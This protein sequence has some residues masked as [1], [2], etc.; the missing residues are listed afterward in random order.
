MPRDRRHPQLPGPRRVPFGDP[1][2]YVLIAVNPLGAGFTRLRRAP[3]CAPPWPARCEAT[4][5]PTGVAVATLR[6]Q[7]RGHARSGYKH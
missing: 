4:P 2:P 3:P 1:T 6:S 5:V 7:P